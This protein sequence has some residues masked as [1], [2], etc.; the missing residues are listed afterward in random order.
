MAG[1]GSITVRVDLGE[2]DA[3]DERLDRLTGLLFG[4]LRGLDVVSVR[5]QVAPAVAGAKSGV[6]SGTGALVVALA[7][8]PVLSALVGC[9]RAWIERGRDRS[10]RLEC[11]DRVIELTAVSKDLQDLAAAEWIRQCGRSLDID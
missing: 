9:L 4:E 3:D 6:A 1:G 2:G 10:V 8:S 11:G 5:R 7:S